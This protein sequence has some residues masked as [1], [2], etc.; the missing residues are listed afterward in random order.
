M[1]NIHY[2]SFSSFFEKARQTGKFYEIEL[3]LKATYSKEFSH[4]EYYLNFYHLTC[5]CSPTLS[6]DELTDIGVNTKLYLGND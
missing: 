6:I 1:E 5:H 3:V 4:F 2:N